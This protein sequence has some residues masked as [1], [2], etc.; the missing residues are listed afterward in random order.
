MKTVTFYHS[1]ICPRC[2]MAGLFLSRQL[3]DFPD[4]TVEKVEY[5]ANMG[6]SHKADVHTIPSLV[7]GEEKLSG[8]FLTNS[9]KRRFLEAL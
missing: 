1:V 6:S 8:F 7:A 3:R 4:V 9:G 5:L 2:F